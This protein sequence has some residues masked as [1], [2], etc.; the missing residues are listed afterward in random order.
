MTGLPPAVS[1]SEVYCPTFPP[2]PPVR[3]V[4]S[5]GALAAARSLRLG[6]P[7]LPLEQTKELM[8]GLAPA[9]SCSEVYSPT[10]PVLSRV[11][12]VG[13]AAQV[14]SEHTASFRSPL[15]LS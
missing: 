8:T 2:P 1:C 11:R 14:A 4:R 6:R 9:V 10:F 7:R 5:R 12:R 15:V 13:A 3:T